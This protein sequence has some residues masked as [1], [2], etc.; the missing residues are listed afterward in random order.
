MHR[1]ECSSSTD[2]LRMLFKSLDIVEQ[3]KPL[4]ALQMS[5][6]GFV[7]KDYIPSCTIL[8][9]TAERENDPSVCW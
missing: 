8:L 4:V 9:S 6:K 7:K 5:I 2:V 3:T 1:I